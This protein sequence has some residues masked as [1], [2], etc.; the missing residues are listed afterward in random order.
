MIMFANWY[1]I[2]RS[3][4]DPNVLNSQDALTGFKTE[5]THLDGR[6]IF[7]E[8]NTVIWPGEKILKEGEGMPKYEDISSL[9]N[10]IIT[11]DVHFPKNDLTNQDKEGNFECCIF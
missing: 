1:C 3:I 6:K 5:I 9:G 10:L 8:R 4:N 7:I 11:V 2:I